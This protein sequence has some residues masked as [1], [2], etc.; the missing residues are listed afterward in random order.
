MHGRAQAV[1]AR[2]PSAL[3]LQGVSDG[4]SRFALSEAIGI[5]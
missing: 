1:E 2:S 4:A 3:G 5:E